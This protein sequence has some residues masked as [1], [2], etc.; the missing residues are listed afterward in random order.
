MRSIL[1]KMPSRIP[2]NINNPFN[3]EADKEDKSINQDFEKVNTE[4]N[5]IKQILT[6]QTQRVNSSKRFLAKLI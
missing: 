3:D 1:R 6:K 5:V 2:D 4:D